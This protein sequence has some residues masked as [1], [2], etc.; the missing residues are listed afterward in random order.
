MRIDPMRR[1]RAHSVAAPDSDCILWT[2]SVGGTGYPTMSIDGKSNRSVTRF[3]LGLTDP[4]IFACHTCDTPRCVNVDHLF[5]GSHSDN[6]RDAVAKRRHG[7]SK[8]THCRNG[9]EFSPDNTYLIKKPTGR[10]TRV[11]RTCQLAAVKRYEQRK[12]RGGE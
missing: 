9:H 2:S 12:A 7:M 1:I 6:M 11:C 10:K 5:A 4:N 3:L 8:K